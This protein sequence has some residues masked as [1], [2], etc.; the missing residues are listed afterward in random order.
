MIP[1]F[2]VANK[3]SR[4]YSIPWQNDSIMLHNFFAM[5][6]MVSHLS[7]HEM[8]AADSSTWTPRC[9]APRRSDNKRRKPRWRRPMRRRRVRR[10]RFSAN[11]GGS[12]WRETD[13]HDTNSWFWSSDLNSGDDGKKCMLCWEVLKGMGIVLLPW[14]II[15]SV[16]CFWGWRNWQW[17]F[18][19][20]LS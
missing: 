2:D 6:L 12:R 10:R 15:Y 19:G 9:R 18:G 11:G 7:S 1:V 14:R 17:S 8:I 16:F 20:S 3:K 5:E 4:T 13:E